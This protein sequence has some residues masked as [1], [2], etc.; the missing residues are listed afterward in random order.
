MNGLDLKTVGVLVVVVLVGAAVLWACILEG[1]LG[2][3]DGDDL[4][5]DEPCP[6][7]G[8]GVCGPDDA[9]AYIYCPGCSVQTQ[10]DEHGA[11]IEHT[12]PVEVEP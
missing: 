10:L 11:I 1:T 6:G 4:E 3:I 2:M 5:L 8:L 12:R 9:G 7:S